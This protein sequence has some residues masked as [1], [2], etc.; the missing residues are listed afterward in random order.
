MVPVGVGRGTDIF[1]RVALIRIRLGFFPLAKGYQTLGV[2]DPGSG[3]KQHRHVELFGDPV[4]F[5]HEVDT[6]LGIRGLYKR[7]LGGTGIVAVIL[8][9]LGGMH[10]GIV[11]RDDHEAAIDA[12][13]GR[14][15]QR[16]GSNIQAHVFHR[17]ETAHTADGGA[18][19][20][21]RGDFFIRRP[22]TVQGVLILGQRFKNLRAGSAGICR[23]D[24]DPGFIGTSR[25]CLVAGKQMFGHQITF[26]FKSCGFRM[27]LLYRKPCEKRNRML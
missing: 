13:V 14:G 2:R 7:D 3:A 1:L 21:L 15:E 4:G 17:T 16:I 18:V 25:D 6:L 5:L 19:G 11:C 9:V 22:L 24:L 27:I 8:L 12:V 20:D 26:C 23:T 10:A